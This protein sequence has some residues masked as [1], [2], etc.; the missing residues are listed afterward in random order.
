MRLSVPKLK[1][2]W[3]PTPIR[4]FT[5]EVSVYIHIE[6]FP[7]FFR[8]DTYPQGQDEHLSSPVSSALHKSICLSLWAQIVG[9]PLGWNKSQSHSVSDCAPPGQFTRLWSGITEQCQLVLCC[10]ELGLDTLQW[11]P[12]QRKPLWQDAP[13]SWSHTS[14][15]ALVC[16][17]N[18]TVRTC[19]FS[20]GTT[21]PCLPGCLT[22][23][24]KILVYEPP[25]AAWVV[26][27]P[28]TKRGC[29]G[30]FHFRIAMHFLFFLKSLGECVLLAE[31]RSGQESI[32]IQSPLCY[33][34]TLGLFRSQFLE[35]A[36]PRLLVDWRHWTLNIILTL[37]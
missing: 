20:R 31:P 8:S 15:N 1:V 6:C 33:H 10:G 19:V 18:L 28:R 7:A 2:E 9:N 26:C 23:K 34:T 12:H 37:T 35:L 3:H 36:S 25:E 21:A 4:E 13:C 11:H 16:N 30:H 27:S 24:P 29:L 5:W 32:R 14:P 17:K 22:T